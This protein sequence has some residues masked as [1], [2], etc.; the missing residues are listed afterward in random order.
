MSTQQKDG[1]FTRPK[2]INVELDKVSEQFLHFFLLHRFGQTRGNK[3]F[4]SVLLLHHLHRH[5]RSGTVGRQ[6]VLIHVQ[7]RESGKSKLNIEYF[8][9][10]NC[11]RLHYY[12]S[13]VLGDNNHFYIL[14]ESTCILKHLDETACR[15]FLS[16]NSFLT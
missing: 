10:P 15:Y 6:R 13:F 3:S 14:Y 7:R 1:Y 4:K 8:I 5:L 11:V 16:F 9:G 12:L 2:K